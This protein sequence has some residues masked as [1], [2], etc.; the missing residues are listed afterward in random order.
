MKPRHV[1][2]SEVRMLSY[3]VLGF[4]VL[5]LV[6]AAIVCVAD[7]LGTLASILVGSLITWAVSRR[8]YKLASEDLTQEAKN[9][10]WLSTIMLSVLEKHGL[11][12]FVRNPS[13]DIT[14]VK[15]MKDV[16]GRLVLSVPYQELP[17][18]V[19][20]DFLSLSSAARTIS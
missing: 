18:E 12:N 10:R 8:Y 13:G 7:G 5:L 11:A 9:L 20:F 14:A 2:Q 19:L 17:P 16:H 6:Y 1:R 3:W 15:E 4:F